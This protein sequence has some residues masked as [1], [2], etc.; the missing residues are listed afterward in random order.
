MVLNVF[1]FVF[2]S[3]SGRRYSRSNQQG[4]SE[5]QEERNNEKNDSEDSDSSSSEKDSTALNQEEST[6]DFVI[7]E[8]YGS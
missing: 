3:Y 6:S 7:D 1:V 5:V 8:D 2:S 4:K